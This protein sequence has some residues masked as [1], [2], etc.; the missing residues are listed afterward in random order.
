MR[1]SNQEQRFKLIDFLI[2]RLDH[3]IKYNATVTRLIY[4]VN[5]AILSTVYFGFEKVQPVSHAY[6]VTGVLFLLLF[7]INLFHANFLHIQH[8][9]YRT[10]DQE[11]R[12][13]FL[14]FK[15]FEKIWPKHLG[16]CHDEVL[17]EKEYK[18][19]NRLFFFR[20]TQL[21]YVWIHLV[22]A[23]FLLLFCLAFFY[24]LCKPF[25]VGLFLLL[26]CLAFFR[27]KYMSRKSQCSN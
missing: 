27:I 24:K 8:V 3:T 15:D 11:I 7:I 19:L 4:V 23:F 10:I 26:F 14:G 1:R 13:V 16:I 17:K 22:V 9:W 12:K 25:A 6:F 18:G 20:K 21:I 5:G 2:K